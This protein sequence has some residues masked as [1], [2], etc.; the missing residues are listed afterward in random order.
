MA[1]R[2]K[3]PQNYFLNEQHSCVA[4]FTSVWQL[5]P[6]NLILH[7]VIHN[8]VWCVSQDLHQKHHSSYSNIRK[9]NITWMSV[10]I[11]FQCMKSVE[12]NP[13]AQGCKPNGECHNAAWYI[14]WIAFFQQQSKLTK[15]NMHQEAILFELIKL[16]GRQHWN[17]IIVP[18][19]LERNFIM[20][21]L[22]LHIEAFL[23]HICDCRDQSGYGLSKWKK[24]S[25]SNSS[26]HWLSPY[27]EWSLY[28]RLDRHQLSCKTLPD[29]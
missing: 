20:T 8:Q 11:Q 17:M 24:A 23:M 29:D 12:E 1:S 4:D 16:F 19:Y 27:P 21:W 28:W 2:L 15:T 7:F 18:A 9:Y 14:N 5:R 6:E 26:S 25:H 3:T 10:P 22:N 13:T